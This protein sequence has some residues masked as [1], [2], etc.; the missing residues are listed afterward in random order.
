METYY[1]TFGQKHAHPETHEPMRD[2]YIKINAPS[3][4]AARNK[5]SE[6]FKNKWAFQYNEEEF[7]FIYFPGGCYAEI[8]VD[9]MPQ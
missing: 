1:F 7:R 8:N 6:L 4:E 3:Y 9:V 2:H 5:M